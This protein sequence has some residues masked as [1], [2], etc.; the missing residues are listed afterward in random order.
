VDTW[1]FFRGHW[2]IIGERGLLQLVLL[3]AATAWITGVVCG[4]VFIRAAYEERIATMEHRIG[5]LRLGMD[6][7]ENNIGLIQAPQ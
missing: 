1:V 7:L 2:K 5:A 6:K 3:L 4:V